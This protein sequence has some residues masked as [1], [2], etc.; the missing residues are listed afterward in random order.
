M[1]KK[2]FKE[3]NPTTCKTWRLAELWEERQRLMKR[4]AYLEQKP[5]TTVQVVNS[6]K[7]AIKIHNKEFAL[8]VRDTKDLGALARKTIAK[9]PTFSQIFSNSSLSFLK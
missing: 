2:P 7:E 3:I 9:L 1:T 5:L 4:V 8:A 6:C